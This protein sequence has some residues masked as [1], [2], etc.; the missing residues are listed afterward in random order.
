MAGCRLAV[1]LASD[2]DR[3]EG[4]GQQFNSVGPIQLVGIV[5]VVVGVVFEYQ[6]S[7]SFIYPFV[8]RGGY[9]KQDLYFLTRPIYTVLESSDKK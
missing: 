8:R 1:L 7:P 5:W 3:G 4:H 6:F 2:L 9:I